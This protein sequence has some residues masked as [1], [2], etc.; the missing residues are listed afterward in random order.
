MLSVGLFRIPTTASH[1]T[2]AGEERQTLSI[3]NFAR[4]RFH[5]SR[6]RAEAPSSLSLHALAAGSYRTNEESEKRARSRRRFLPQFPRPPP[7]APFT[8]RGT[9]LR[10]QLRGGEG[11]RGEQGAVGPTPNQL[12]IFFPIRIKRLLAQLFP[13]EDGIRKSESRN[14][15]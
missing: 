2:D 1:A 7:S 8:E 6:E 9:R 5:S 12:L 10:K 13:L 15:H 4:G 14:H 3:R 11:H